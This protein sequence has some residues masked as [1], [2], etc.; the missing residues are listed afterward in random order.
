MI[1]F[2]VCDSLHQTTTKV[3]TGRQDD[4]WWHFRTSNSRSSVFL[5]FI[6]FLWIPFRYANEWRISRVVQS[7][8]VWI[9]CEILFLWENSGFFIFQQKNTFF[10]YYQS[11][12]ID[13]KKLSYRQLVSMH[14]SQIF[15]VKLSNCHIMIR[16]KVKKISNLNCEENVKIENQ[17]FMI[18][19]RYISHGTRTYH[20][21]LLPSSSRSNSLSSFISFASIFS[22]PMLNVAGCDDDGVNVFDFNGLW[23]WKIWEWAN[24]SMTSGAKFTLATRISRRNSSSWHFVLQK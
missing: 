4:E 23:S 15:P 18:S 3:E 11:I 16:N 22:A 17:I 8:I 5:C 9:L 2:F 12:F 20:I 19:H 7:L 21:N 10:L 1:I 24:T 13:C 14:A 6:V